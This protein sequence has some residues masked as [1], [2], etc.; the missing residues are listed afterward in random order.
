MKICYK[1]RRFD[2][3]ITFYGTFSEMEKLRDFMTRTDSIK[4][5]Y[6]SYFA[7]L[8]RI[9]GEL[10]LKLTLFFFFLFFFFFFFSVMLIS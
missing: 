5:L 1:E 8:I 9:S 3:Q 10:M 4:L 6:S 7:A 2:V